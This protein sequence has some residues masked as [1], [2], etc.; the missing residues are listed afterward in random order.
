MIERIH[1]MTASL[2][3][4]E[5][6]AAAPAVE[7]P[8]VV[9]RRTID[10]VLIALGAVATV[11]LGVAGGLL[12]WGHNFADDYVNRE[13]SSQNIF[14][15]SA[16]ELTEEGRT[17]LVRFAD[18]QVTT[19][20]E[21][22]AYASFINGHLQGI[23]DGATYADLGATQSEAR[24]ALA[25]AQDNDASASEIATLQQNVDTITGQ[26]DTLFKGET[27]RGLLLSSYAWATVGKIAGIA[28]IVAFIATAVMLV[29]VVAGLVHIGR[30]HEHST[31]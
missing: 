28:A 17:D 19:G 3:S 29:L 14:F 27:L 8:V 12:L 23:A 2:V 11:V 10:L 4:P 26:R 1:P 7:Q 22:E 18:E 16:D 9:R 25:T 5:V 15:P 20:P 21:A 6:S 31:T 13:L 24:A 30:R